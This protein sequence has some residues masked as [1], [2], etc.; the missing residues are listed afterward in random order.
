ML[1]FKTKQ[2]LKGDVVCRVQQ[3]KISFKQALKILS[4]SERTLYR[5]LQNHANEGARFVQHKNCYKI[6]RIKSI[7]PSK[8]KYSVYAKKLTSTLTALMPWK[9]SE[10]TIKSKSRKPLSMISVIAIT[11]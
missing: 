4:I 1:T 9:N 2:Q 5:Y 3:G 10:T 7:L 8:K 6:Q 11:F